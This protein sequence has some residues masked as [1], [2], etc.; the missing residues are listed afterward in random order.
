MKLAAFDDL[1]NQIQDQVLS[2]RAA[3]TAGKNGEVGDG[4]FTTFASSV[5]SAVNW[6]IS[7]VGNVERAF[8]SINLDVEF[9]RAEK[10][11]QDGGFSSHVAAVN[12][13]LENFT[14]TNDGNLGHVQS[15]AA[16]KGQD[17]MNS[18]STKYQVEGTLI[19]RSFA[20][21][22]NVLQFNR[23]DVNADRLWRAWNYMRP[24][25]LVADPLNQHDTFSRQLREESRVNPSTA[26]RINM[27]SEMFKGSAIVGLVHFVNI[28]TARM[29]TTLSVNRTASNS[30]NFDAAK[31]MSDQDRQYNST[32]SS[33][34]NELINRL[35]KMGSNAGLEVHFS[36]ACVGYIPAISTNQVQLA[37]AQMANFDPANFKV[38]AMDFPDGTSMIGAV[39]SNMKSVI[40]VTIDSVARVDEASR[41]KVLDASAFMDAFTD[42]T[43]A[44]QD[45]VRSQNIGAPTGLNMRTFTKLDVLSALANK[46]LNTGVNLAVDVTS[47]NDAVPPAMPPKRGA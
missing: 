19:V 45:P 46:Y 1:T 23:L 15:A 38:P 36:L 2:L 28:T 42:Y 8:D 24:D 16:K 30:S 12:K 41:L 27:V 11:D 34:A 10:N 33:R 22:R 43:K 47:D 18:F 26:D 9:I 29:N 4:S 40:D 3:S 25:N 6:G 14:R 13:Y 7:A 20:T 39:Q 31:V 17:Q 32:N 5:E 21:H 44:A 37:V 35:A